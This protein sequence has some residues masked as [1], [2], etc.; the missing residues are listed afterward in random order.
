MPF[1]ASQCIREATKSAKFF[2]ISRNLNITAKIKLYPIKICTRISLPSSRH[3]NCE[4]NIATWI[5][6]VKSLTQNK[7]IH[8]WIWAKLPI[9]SIYTA[10]LKGPTSTSIIF[11]VTCLCACLPVSEPHRICEYDFFLVFIGL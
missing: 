3:P 4:E 6:L 9:I 8:A 10:N 2:R 1:F 11:Q 7:K 5:P